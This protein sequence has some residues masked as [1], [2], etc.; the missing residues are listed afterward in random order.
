MNTSFSQTRQ[1]LVQTIHTQGRRSL[2]PPQMKVAYWWWKK[3]HL[4]STAEYLTVTGLPGKREYLALP[5]S[6]GY[7]L[8][9]LLH[10][11]QGIILV[12]GVAYAFWEELLADEV[13]TQTWKEITQS[14]KNPGVGK[15]KSSSVRL[16]RLVWS[17]ALFGWLCVGM[18]PSQYPC[19]MKSKKHKRDRRIPKELFYKAK[20]TSQRRFKHLLITYSKKSP[21]TSS[22][23][24]P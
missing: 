11:H 6:W 8:S 22:S 9:S 17:T 16:W 7:L 20:T 14:G 10:L 18:F 5:C 4:S 19:C 2:L 12:S 23:L 15:N 3:S 21:T 24:Q 1:H 13:L